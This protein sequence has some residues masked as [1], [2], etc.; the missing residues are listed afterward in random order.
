MSSHLFSFKSPYGRYAWKRFHLK[1]LFQS[2]S[3]SRLSSRD[4]GYFAEVKSPYFVERNKGSISSIIT[5]D[6]LQIGFSM[7]STAVVWFEG[8]VLLA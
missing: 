4:F 2:L 3:L 5:R 6:Y 8:F 7:S 1:L